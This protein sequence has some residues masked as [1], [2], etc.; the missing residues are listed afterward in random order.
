MTNGYAIAI[1]LCLIGLAGASGYYYGDKH[2]T[3]RVELEAKTAMDEHLR[4]DRKAEADA[5]AKIKALETDLVLAQDA[6]GTAYEKGKKDAE[7]KGEAVVAG[8]P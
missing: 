6:A 7:Q 8:L 2:A 3:T 4:A 5:Q 1:A